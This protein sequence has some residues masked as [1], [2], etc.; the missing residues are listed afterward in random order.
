[1]QALRSHLLGLSTATMLAFLDFAKP[2]FLPKKATLRLASA[3]TRSIAAQIIQQDSIRH[4]EATSEIHRVA[5]LVGSGGNSE[6]LSTPLD[7][8]WHEGQAR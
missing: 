8:F 4:F 6:A 5:D 3:V 7:H 1:M 2:C